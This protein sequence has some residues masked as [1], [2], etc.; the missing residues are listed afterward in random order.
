MVSRKTAFSNRVRRGVGLLGGGRDLYA[1][2]AIRMESKEWIFA[3]GPEVELM[4][5]GAGD[6]FAAGGSP[7]TFRMIWPSK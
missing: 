1:K 7:V 2:P 5:T 4:L 6:Y 3:V